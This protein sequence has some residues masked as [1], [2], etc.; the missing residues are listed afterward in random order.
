MSLARTIATTALLAA[1]TVAAAEIPRD[2]RRSGFTFMTPA[3]QA[4][5]TDDTA[6][7]GMLCVL[8]GEA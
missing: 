4:M 3:T 7:P 1:T 6:N 8:D 2:L 5:Q